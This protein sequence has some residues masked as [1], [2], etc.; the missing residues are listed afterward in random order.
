MDQR[1][2]HSV[3]MTLY[4]SYLV[5][6]YLAWVVWVAEGDVKDTKVKTPYTL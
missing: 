3:G 1:E 5:E 6:A 4:H 2:V